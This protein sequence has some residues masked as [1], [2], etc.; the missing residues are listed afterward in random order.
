MARF[1]IEI[2][3]GATNHRAS[4]AQNYILQKGLKKFGQAG[5]DAD[6]KELDQLH[7]CHCFSPRDVSTMTAE[8]K[9][10]ALEA[11]MF[12][13]EKRDKSIKGRMVANGKPSGKWL[14]RED[15]TSPTAALESI[16]LTAVVDAHEGR[17]DVMSGDV[18][19]AFIQTKMPPTV[20]GEARVI[21]KIKGVLLN[22]LV[23]LCNTQP[24]HIRNSGSQTGLSHDVT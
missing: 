19:N 21:L 9:R 16:M 14:D 15:S 22:L 10:K 5:S 1:I 3:K 12:L 2:N 11:L 6:S 17:G 7:T 18:P 8:K 24:I 23:Q 13:T 4:F 20:D